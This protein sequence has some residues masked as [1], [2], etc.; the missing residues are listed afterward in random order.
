MHDIIRAMNKQ[1]HF[2]PQASEFL[3]EQSAAV[4]KS[5]I[6]APRPGQKEHGTDLDRDLDDLD[7]KKESH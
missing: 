5:Q 1:L 2:T 7:Q 4:Q 6:A 3:T